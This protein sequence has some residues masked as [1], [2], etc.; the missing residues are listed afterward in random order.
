MLDTDNRITKLETK[1][2]RVESDNNQLFQAVMY[3]IGFD[4]A[5][6]LFLF[7]YITVLR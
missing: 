1:I 2:V 6:L 5:L 3:L 7:F 4:V